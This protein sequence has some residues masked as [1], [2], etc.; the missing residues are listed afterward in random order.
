MQVRAAHLCILQVTSPQ[1]LLPA[2]PTGCVTHRSGADDVV[3]LCHMLTVLLLI[4]NEA[5]LA[6]PSQF[7]WLNILKCNVVTHDC[8]RKTIDGDSK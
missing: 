3:D 1:P 8:H 5:S 7:C 2:M 6:K 4:S